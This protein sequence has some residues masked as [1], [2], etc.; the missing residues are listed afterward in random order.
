MGPGFE[1][2]KRHQNT[3][4]PRRSMTCGA[5]FGLAGGHRKLLKKVP[6][7]AGWQIGRQHRMFA[8]AWIAWCRATGRAANKS[9]R[10]RVA[11]APQP[12]RCQDNGAA[13]ALRVGPPT[14]HRHGSRSAQRADAKASPVRHPTARGRSRTA[15]QWALVMHQTNRLRLAVLFGS[16]LQRRCPCSNICCSRPKDLRLPKPRF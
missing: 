11:A 2:L 6:H 5:F 7:S 4:K 14:N 1:S 16:S 10:Q 12:D 13:H 15:M 3:Q 9:T 8:P